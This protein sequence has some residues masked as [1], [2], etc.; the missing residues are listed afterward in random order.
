MRAP[1]R[2]TKTVSISGRAKGMYLLEL[3]VNGGKKT[4]KVLKN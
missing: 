3:L 4:F 2:Y 1:G